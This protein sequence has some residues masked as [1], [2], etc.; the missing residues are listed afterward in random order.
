MCK[1]TDH[2]ETGLNL[3]KLDLVWIDSYTTTPVHVIQV[4][5]NNKLTQLRMN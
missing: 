2:D 3:D 5:A 1:Q 4:A